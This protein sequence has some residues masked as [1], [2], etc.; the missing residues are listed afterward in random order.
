MS[1]PRCFFAARGGC[2]GRLDRAHFLP[3]AAMKREYPHGLMRNTL[4]GTL[5]P[6]RR[7]EDFIAGGV[8]WEPVSMDLMVWDP[9]CWTPMCR[10]HHGDFD[11]H[12]FRIRRDELPV[13]VEEFAQQF[14]FLSRLTIEYGASSHDH[15]AEQFDAA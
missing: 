7:N 14:G 4:D 3:K 5:A 11:A 1:R 10:K 12:V 2:D 6:Q 15:D 13:V 9:R 8:A